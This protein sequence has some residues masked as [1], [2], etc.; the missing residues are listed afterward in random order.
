MLP[1]RINDHIGIVKEIIKL[2]GGKISVKSEGLNK[3]TTFIIELP[4]YKTSKKTRLITNLR[5]FV[6]GIR[7]TSNN[8]LSW[9]K[10]AL[11]TYI[12]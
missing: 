10:M 4:I 3:G 11:K 6:T 5:D 9:F 12:F 2:H 1:E 8:G 7:I